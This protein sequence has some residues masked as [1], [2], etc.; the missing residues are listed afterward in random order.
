M[1][2][3]VLQNLVNAKS[4]MPVLS[5]VNYSDRQFLRHPHVFSPKG[6]VYYQNRP[7]RAEYL[8]QII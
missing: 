7:G 4:I 6:F 8:Q 2:Q 3:H 1:S 5:W